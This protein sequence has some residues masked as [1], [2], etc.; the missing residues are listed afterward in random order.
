MDGLWTGLRTDPAGVLIGLVRW[1]TGGGTGS[2]RL[3]G[4]AGSLADQCMMVR[5]IPGQLDELRRQYPGYPEPL[6]EQAKLNEENQEWEAL[7]EVGAN[8]RHRFPHLLFGYHFECVALRRLGRHDE[9][10]RRAAAAIRRLPRGQSLYEDYCFVAQERGDWP[11]AARRWELI[12]R[13]FPKAFWPQMMRAMSLLHLDRAPEADAMMAAVARDWPQEWWARYHYAE[14]AERREDW[15]QAVRRWREGVELF[16]GR[17]DPHARL[18][19]A[20]LRAGDLA[21]AAHVIAD[22]SF[23]FPRDKGIIE[24]RAL[25]R[26]AGGDP[27][28]L[29]D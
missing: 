23:M 17:P 14:L 22:A 16:T 10:E 8:L 2:K 27:G 21:E 28:P 20:L 25:V 3:N 11:E 6:I 5:Y 26:S 7:L 13:R 24:G 15:P 12:S 1:L 4:V 9:S 29:P 18:T 19:K